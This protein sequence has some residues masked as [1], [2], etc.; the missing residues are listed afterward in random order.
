MLVFAHGSNKLSIRSKNWI[1]SDRL[2]SQCLLLFW[3]W[4][5]KKPDQLGSG[6]SAGDNGNT[7]TVPVQSSLLRNVKM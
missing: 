2:I 6:F 4:K 1:P 7:K 3:W 5:G